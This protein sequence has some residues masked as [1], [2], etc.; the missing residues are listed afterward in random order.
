LLLKSGQKVFEQVQVDF[1]K[2]LPNM[3]TAIHDKLHEFAKGHVA[4]LCNIII[5]N[6]APIKDEKGIEL[7]SYTI[8][9]PFG[10][11]RL[12]LTDILSDLIVCTPDVL[13]KVPTQ[14]WKV[15]CSWFLEYRFNNLY[16]FHFW[17]IY[18][19]VIKENHVESQKNILLK[20]KFLA[21]MIEHYKS[22]EPSGVRGF[23]IVMC[24][25]LRFAADIQLPSAFLRNYINSLDLWKNFL[26]QL[27]ADT[28]LQQKRYDDLIYMPEMGEEDEDEAGIDL[29]SSYARS[30]GFEED[31]P[32]ESPNKK[33]KKKKKNKKGKKLQDSV[34]TLPPPQAYNSESSPKKEESNSNSPKKEESSSPRKEM[35]IAETPIEEENIEEESPEWWKDMVQDLKQ[36]EEEKNPEPDNDDWWKELKGEL[37]TIETKQILA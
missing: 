25:T 37:T 32:L 19:T 8:K 13:E 5:Q 21:K 2:P 24:N 35:K 28:Q 36:E 26:P 27:R 9:R 14:T 6:D 11:Y 10:F 30:L 3:L 4:L 23:I 34:D 15:L 29:G 7:Q 31:K 18:Q 20:Q 16:H 33:K 1:S 12:M 17:K 22:N